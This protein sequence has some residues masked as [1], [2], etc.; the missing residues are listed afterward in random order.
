MWMKAKPTAFWFHF[1]ESTCV[2]EIGTWLSWRNPDK[3]WT[4]NLLLTKTMKAGQGRKEIPH[5]TGKS[6]QRAQ[7]VAQEIPPE[8]QE[9]SVTGYY[10]QS[11]CLKSGI[12]VEKGW[13]H[14]CK[15]FSPQW[16]TWAVLQQHGHF[17]FTWDFCWNLETRFCNTSH[18]SLVWEDAPQH[19]NLVQP[20]LNDLLLISYMLV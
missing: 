10:T 20:E 6:R 8:H 16:K 4:N 1:S 18:K 15:C 19:G 17:L 5:K 3:L 13:W 7:T 12:W 11:F 14:G 2:R 9:H